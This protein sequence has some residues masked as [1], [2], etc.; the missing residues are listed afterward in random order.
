M[1]LP[2]RRFFLISSLSLLGT[3]ASQAGVD[4]ILSLKLVCYYQD[5]TTSNDTVINSTGATVR[6]DSKQLLSLLSKK[7]GV[8]YPGGT[9]LKVSTEGAV[10]IADSKGKVLGDV[11][12]YLQMQFK[13][14]ESIFTGRRNLQ[15]GFEVSRNYYPVSFTIDLPGLTGTVS[16]VAIENFSVSNPNRDRV[17]ISIGNTS[18]SVNGQGLVDGKLGYYEGSVTLKGREA[19]VLAP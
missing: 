15:T 18:A 13:T 19:V 9:Q 4:S 1:K 11:S 3:L 5:K 14:D 6:L 16:G 17:Q 7:L 2:I 10:F 8:K 12:D